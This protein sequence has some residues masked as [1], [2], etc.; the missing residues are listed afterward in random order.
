[1]PQ[2]TCSADAC[3]RPARKKGFCTAHYQKLRRLTLGHCAEDGCMQG[4]HAAKLCRRHYDLALSAGK[5]CKVDGCGRTPRAVGLCSTHYYRL[6]KHG[7]PGEA[8][9]RRKPPRP[10]IVEGCENGATTS[11]D[12]CPTHARRKRLYGT[13]HGTFLT[14][15]KCVVCAVPAMHGPHSSEH[16]EKHYWELLLD[17]HLRGKFEAGLHP[18]GYTY[19]AVRK[20]RQAVHRL[21]MERVLGR[22]LEPFENVH[23]KNGRRADNRPE[24]L[25]LWT[26]PQAIGQRP[27]DLVDWVLDHYLE[28]V[29]ERLKERHANVEQGPAGGREAR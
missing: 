26:K 29:E 2:V 23:H 17:L 6:V 20:R 18:S 21:V 12:L 22:P 15:Q 16:C 3:D 4:V 7:D 19:L 28:L 9:L 1:M 13:E 25:E 24:N 10:C 14:H 27:E 5:S 11:R 8:G